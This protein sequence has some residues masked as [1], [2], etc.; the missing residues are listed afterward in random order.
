VTINEIQ[1]QII[2]E[3]SSRDDLTDKYKYIVDLAKRLE[4]PD[5]NLRSEEN[6]IKGCQSNVWIK[7]EYNDNKIYLW[8]DSDSLIM[9]GMLAL[10]IRVFNNQSPHDILNTDLYFIHKTGLNVNLSPASADGL[11]AIINH[12]KKSVENSIK[13]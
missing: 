1:G 8:G 7:T 2:E 10:L 9:K 11:I 5:G 6:F 13:S 3:L 12:I 4:S